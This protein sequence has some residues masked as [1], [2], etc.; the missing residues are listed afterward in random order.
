[1][2]AIL[3]SVSHSQR[4]LERY[5]GSAR[6][7]SVISSW[8]ALPIS[9]TAVNQFQAHLLTENERT[10]QLEAAVAQIFSWVSNT[11]G[12]TLWL[13]VTV[14]GLK[15]VCGAC[16]AVSSLPAPSSTVKHKEKKNPS[17]LPP[18]QW[19][20]VSQPKHNLWVLFL[21]ARNTVQHG[22]E[23]GK[24]VQKG[25]MEALPWLKL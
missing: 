10:N 18:D 15:S 25:E 5:S 4:M 13:R 16:A 9:S 20:P 6:K 3:L 17:L 8:R 21:G 7:R 14:A 12:I 11:A 2:N 19:L 24:E 22:E 1:M 23:G